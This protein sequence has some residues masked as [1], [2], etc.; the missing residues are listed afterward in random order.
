VL[1]SSS[2]AESK[3]VEVY[4]VWACPQAFHT[5][6]REHEDGGMEGKVPSP[7]GLRMILDDVIGFPGK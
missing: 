2:R 4:P 6:H 5:I 7:R 1:S 3:T